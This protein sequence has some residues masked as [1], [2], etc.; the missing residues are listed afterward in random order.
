MTIINIIETDVQ[1]VIAKIIKYEKLVW[2]DFVTFENWLASMSPLADQALQ[3]LASLA[4]IAAPLAAANPGVAA[5]L[6]LTVTVADEADA[7]VHQVAANQAANK[8][9]NSVNTANSLVAIVGAVNTTHGK[10]AAA[11]GTLSAAI[12]QAVVQTSTQPVPQA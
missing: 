4:Q 10:I 2:A 11:K 8:A 3:E 1:N 5:A 12:A 7:V 9:A 6:A